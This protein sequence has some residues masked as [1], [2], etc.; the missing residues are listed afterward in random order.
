MKPL[1]PIAILIDSGGRPVV[2]CV[3]ARLFFKIYIFFIFFS[4]ANSLD[5]YPDCTCSDHYRKSSMDPQIQ[6][7]D[8]REFFAIILISKEIQEI[9]K[10]GFCKYC[11]QMVSEKYKKAK[12]YK[13]VFILSYYTLRRRDSQ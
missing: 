1:V 9:K 2:G 11:N 10:D 7:Q 8:V 13:K 5:N 4:I 12:I 6:I 3:G